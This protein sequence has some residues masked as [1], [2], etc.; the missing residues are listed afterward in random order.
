MKNLQIKTA[1]P[2]IFGLILLLTLLMGFMAITGLAKTHKATEDLAMNWMPSIAVVGT[3][4]TNISDLRVAESS[5]L[6]ATTPESIQRAETDITDVLADFRKNQKIYEPL[7]S[8]DAERNSYQEFLASWAEY[9]KL[10]EAFIALI[11]DNHME[12]ATALFKGDMLTVFDRMS[13]VPDRLLALNNEGGQDSF[14]ES[15]KS[16][17]NT[18]LLTYSSLAGVLVTLLL[19]TVFVLRSITAPIGRITESMAQLA[20]GDTGTAVPFAGRKDEIGAMAA[21]VEVFRQAALNTIRLES[22]AATAQAEREALEAESRQ[23]KEEEARQLAFA[24]KNLAE[25]LDHLASGDLTY[26]I[27]QPFA[28][29]YDVLRQDFNRSVQQLAATLGEI[30]VAIATVDE[31]TREISSGA[32]DLSKRT[33]QQAAALEETAAALEQITANVQN[34]SKRTEEARSVA[35]HANAAASESLAVVGRAE[36]AMRK[37]EGSSQQISNIIGVIDEIAFQTNLLALNAGVEAARAGEAGKGFA[38]VAQEVRE[39]AQRSATAAKEIK[40][41]IHNSAQEVNEG[42]SLVQGASEALT[43]IGS[44]IA[45][46]NEHMESIAT[47][48]REQSVGLTQVNVAV[49]QM[50]H[51]T[52]QNAAMVEESSAA[53]STLA[54]TAAQLRD[55]VGQFSLTSQNG[56]R[57]GVRYAVAKAA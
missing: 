26:Q 37:I 21:A 12:A 6:L 14:A 30:V 40:A 51:T 35:G 38:V 47:A 25:G 20:A 48:A 49:N 10:H 45:Q 29:A 46:I 19:S 2:G 16:Y 41:L 42:V 23:R 17:R 3:I 39:L 53:A 43:T 15:S 34:S 11:R 28:E 9:F 31:G 33:E 50:D 54:A 27:A 7:I 13:D 57:S 5:R 32:T 18:E 1:M 8:S 55:L 4:N 22:E 52:Q 36:S 24:T 44:F 56:R